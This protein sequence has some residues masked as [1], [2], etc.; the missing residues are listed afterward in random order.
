V[1]RIDQQ[2]SDGESLFYK[3]NKILYNNYWPAFI[4]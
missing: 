1:G 4:A 2:R 3:N